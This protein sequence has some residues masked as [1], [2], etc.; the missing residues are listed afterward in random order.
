MKTLVTAFLLQYPLNSFAHSTGGLHTHSEI[1]IGVGI[2]T[3]LGCFLLSKIKNR[4]G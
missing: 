3:F 4:K 2:A 1:M